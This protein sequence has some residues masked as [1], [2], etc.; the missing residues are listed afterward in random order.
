MKSKTF[1]RCIALI[2]ALAL[3]VSMT[4]C[5][6]DPSYDGSDM[7]T[8]TVEMNIDFPDPEAISDNNVSESEDVESNTGT[9]DETVLEYSEDV[10]GYKMQVE[11]G[12]TVMQIL[13]SFASQNDMEIQVASTDGTVYVTSIDGIASGDV[14]AWIYEI[15]DKSVAEKSSKYIPKNGDKITWEFIKF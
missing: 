5:A 12:A 2:A 15:N 14:S 10:E 13:E 11:N 1:K 8:I 7:D 6:V 4:A 3:M 9:E